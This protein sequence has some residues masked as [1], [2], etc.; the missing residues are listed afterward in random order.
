MA[1][2]E[3]RTAHIQSAFKATTSKDLREQYI[4]FIYFNYYYYYYYY[5]NIVSFLKCNC[6]LERMEGLMNSVKGVLKL[7]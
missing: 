7:T 5:F 3:A 4:F 1:E 2:F 6:R